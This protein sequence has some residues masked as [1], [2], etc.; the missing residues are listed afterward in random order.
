MSGMPITFSMRIDRLDR[1]ALIF[2]TAAL[3]IIALLV[4]RGDQVGVQVVRTAPESGA[5]DVTTRAQLALT[6]SELMDTASV[7]GRVQLTPLLTGTLRWNGSTAFFVPQTALQPD[8][9]YTVTVQ[10][11]A[12]SA[13]GRPFLRDWQ[14]SFHTGHP[15]MV[16]L[17]PATDIGDLYRHEAD[18]TSPA[19]RLTSEPNGVFDYAISPDGKRI[20]Y[21]ATRDETGARDLWIVN[22]D[23]SGR[24]RL[25]A[26]VDMICQAPSWSADGLV[27]AYEQRNLVAGPQGNVPGPSRI[28][29]FDINSRTGAPLLSD[30]Q[31]LGTLP[32][33]APVGQSL[34]YYDPQSSTITVVDVVSGER[35]Q[36][37]S[38]MGDSGAW[39]PNGQQIVY[40]ELVAV[41][42]GSYS[43]LLRAD[44]ARGVIT[45]V[46][47]LSNT[48]DASVAWSPDG[49]LIAF[50]RQR[51]GGAGFSALGSQIWI[52]T[53]EGDI[54]RQV[55]DDPGF[56]YGGLAWSPDS[57]WLAVVRNN[58]QIP[59]P[60]PEVWLVR[61]DGKQV[62]RVMENATLPAW[63]P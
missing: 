37:P 38:V 57:Q 31:E 35:T 55:T 58:L 21:S 61:A 22:T 11:G 30:S 25:L 54:M 49:T 52:S 46:M 19:V 14:W 62:I 44:V 6:F 53:P 27:V 45:A 7:E 26:C 8:T 47:P 9:L 32:R 20:V 29:L 39:S 15:R 12:V 1:A 5:T 33:W 18:G 40:P 59:N 23:G 56:I 50:T 41:D 28:W 13:R 43:Q 4:A 60:Q 48:N 3:T 34:A 10:S 24:E 51:S 17:A 36:L 42:A 2:I 63:I 16:Y